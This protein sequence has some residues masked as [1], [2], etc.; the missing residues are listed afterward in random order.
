MA[1]VIPPRRAARKAASRTAGTPAASK[2]TSAPPPVRSFTPFSASSGAKTAVAPSCRASSR[3]A[4]TGSTAMMG[5]AFAT[6]A[7]I[8]EASPTPPR[9]KMATDWPGRTEAVLRTAPAPV[10]TAQPKSAAVWSGTSLGITTA[11]SRAI[12][13]WRAKAGDPQVVVDA[14]PVPAGE[15]RRAVE[16]GARPRWPAAAGRAERR[17]RPTSTRRRCRS[18][19]R[20]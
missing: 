18:W 2:V 8:T 14:L 4:G 7:P 1:T 15:Q 16:Q 11:D 12:T 17:A 5:Q 19:A 20:R 3:L 9:P 13:A 10:S 6:S